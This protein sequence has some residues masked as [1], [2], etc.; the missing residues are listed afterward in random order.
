MGQSLMFAI[1]PPVARNLGLT[2]VQVGSIFAVSA[3]LWVLA[4]PFW[5]RLSDIWGRRP[6]ILVGLI[7]YTVS[8]AS[9]GLCVQAG[10]SGWSALRPAYVLKIGTRAIFC[11][12]SSAKV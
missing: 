4:S 7:G 1:L 10:L 8:M 6:L 3:L 9:F 12:L 2:E 11:L 5:G